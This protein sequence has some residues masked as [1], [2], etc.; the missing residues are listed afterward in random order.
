MGDVELVAPF[1][2]EYTSGLG[3]IDTLV[4]EVD[5]V[6]SSESVLEVPL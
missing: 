1:L 2:E 5:V 6:P 3:F 4:G